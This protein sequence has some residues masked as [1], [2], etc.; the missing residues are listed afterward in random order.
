MPDLGVIAHAPEQVVHDARRAPAAPGDLMGP[1]R[2]DLHIEQV[3]RADDDFLQIF[4]N[5]VIQPF[6][7]PEPR[8]QRRGEQ[9]AARRRADEREARQVQPDA[10]GVR[11]L[12]N[13]DV[14]LE[15]LH[16][17]I[18][19]FLDGFLQA[20]DLVN[21]QHVA[22]LKVRE[23]AGK[24]GG[25]FNRRAA[26]G[27]EAAAHG[28]GQDVGDGG[29]TQAG[30]AAQQDVIQRLAALLG[31]GHG[32]L[33]PFLDLGLA[34]EIGKERGTQRHFERDIRFVQSG[35]GAFGHHNQLAE[36]EA[37]RQ[38]RIPRW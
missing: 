7:H 12:V 2:F 6:A 14:Q 1:G 34:G 26:G 5:V 35:S 23:Q 8:Q 20:M 17:G 36:T 24:V 27:F 18:E 25:F 37:E 28:F 16:R 19:I 33:E 29:L 21:E 38:A 9:A 32:D 22:F 30:R 13:D 10:A 31:G 11:P 3:C 4:A 15:I